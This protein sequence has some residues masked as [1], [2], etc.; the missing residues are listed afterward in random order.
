M[1]NQVRFNMVAFD[2]EAY[3]QTVKLRNEVLRAP[4]GLV[5]TED[6]RKNEFSDFHV[7]GFLDKN[8]IACMVLSPYSG[9]TMKMRQVAVSSDFQGN[10]IG[11]S[12]IVEGEKICRNKNFDRIVLNARDKVVPFYLK[13]DYKIISEI[14]I[15]VNIPHIKMEKIL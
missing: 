2:S 14:F 12:M 8:V 9:S 5:L 3:N 7:A 6:E 1:K 11:K 15:E 13:L 4:L 10:G